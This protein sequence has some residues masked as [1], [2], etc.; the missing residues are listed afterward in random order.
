M[1]SHYADRFCDN[2]HCVDEDIMLL[3]CQVTSREHRLPV[4]VSHYLAMFRGHWS[5]ARGTIKYLLCHMISQKY[6]I[7]GQ[8]NFMRK[9]SS[10]Y[11][12]TFPGMVAIGIAVVEI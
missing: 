8:S 12:T 7:E 4:T 9:S 11:V 3:I 2:K 1:L 6:L 5:S 10:W